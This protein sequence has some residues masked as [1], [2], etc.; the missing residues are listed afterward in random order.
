MKR[1]EKVREQMF[2][3]KEH[4]GPEVRTGS[5]HWRTSGKAVKLVQSWGES[6]GGVAPS[7]EREGQVGLGP[8]GRSKEPWPSFRVRRDVPGGLEAARRVKAG[9]S[10]HAGPS[11][12]ARRPQTLDPR[13]SLLQPHR[14]TTPWETGRDRRTQTAPAR[15]RSENLPGSWRGVRAALPGRLGLHTELSNRRGGG[16][17]RLHLTA[18]R[19][20][21]RQS[22]C[23]T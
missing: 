10:G 22:S 19:V 2:Q 5:G 20:N 11:A 1:P 17:Q 18:N 14:E 23:S 16:T 3:R 21:L 4:M 13:R 7:E 8:A 12:E 15:T 9:A 6:G